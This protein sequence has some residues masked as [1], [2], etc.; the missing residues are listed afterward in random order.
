MITGSGK[1]QLWNG[2]SSFTPVDTIDFHEIK[3]SIDNSGAN[4]VTSL[5]VRQPSEYEK[6]HIPGAVLIPLPQIAGRM[7]KIDR[8]HPVF[9]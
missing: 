5:D 6:S 8:E 4:N 1:G 2:A 3:A 9:K 7:T